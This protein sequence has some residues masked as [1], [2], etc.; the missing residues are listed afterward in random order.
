[1]GNGQIEIQTVRPILNLSTDLKSALKNKFNKATC[2]KVGQ[3]MKIFH[4]TLAFDRLRS[5]VGLGL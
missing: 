2:R 4:S 3:K 1:M 5:G